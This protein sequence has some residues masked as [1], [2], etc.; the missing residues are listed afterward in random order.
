MHFVLGG[1]ITKHVTM[2]IIMWTALYIVFSIY[3]MG[4]CPIITIIQG[5][6]N[7]MV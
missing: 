4:A 1:A 7:W 2:F 5:V 6:L 3:Y